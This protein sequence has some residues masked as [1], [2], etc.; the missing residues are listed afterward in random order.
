MRVHYAVYPASELKVQ[1]V[2]N[3]F[4][5]FFSLKIAGAEKVLVFHHFVA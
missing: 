2:K 3:V 5:S 1:E 4:K